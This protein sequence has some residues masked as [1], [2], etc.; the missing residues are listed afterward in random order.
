MSSKA[1]TTI[2]HPMV[3]EAILGDRET[4]TRTARSVGVE[5]A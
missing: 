1:E 4:G 3:I 5:R 2:S